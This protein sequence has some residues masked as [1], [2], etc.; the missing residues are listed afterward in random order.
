[1]KRL[2]M[3]F[4]YRVTRLVHEMDLPLRDEVFFSRNTQLATCV[5]AS[6]PN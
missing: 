3:Y 2:K 6:D 5:Y 1:M 4:E